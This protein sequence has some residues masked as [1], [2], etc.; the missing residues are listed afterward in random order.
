VRERLGTDVT[1]LTGD[2]RRLR[3]LDIGP[4]D[5]SMTSPPYMTRDNH[6]EDALDGYRSHGGD[7]EQYLEDLR[8]VYVQL[9]ELLRPGAFAVVNVA[10]IRFGGPDITPLA[11][12]VGRTLSD[13]LHFEGEIVICHEVEP[14]ELTNDYCL[15][16]RKPLD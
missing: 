15:V 5:F 2:A 6:P 12:D 7:Y 13:V 4:V 3:E 1:I 14:P 8:D 11:W 9:A 16:F 10:N